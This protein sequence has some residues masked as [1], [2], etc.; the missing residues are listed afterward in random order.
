MRKLRTIIFDYNG[1]LT[2]KEA[3][4]WKPMLKA[5]KDDGYTICVASASTMPKK[6]WNEENELGEGDF[7][8]ILE[9]I[10]GKGRADVLVPFVQQAYQLVQENKKDM[11]LPVMVP[12]KENMLN[13]DDTKLNTLLLG[14]AGLGTVLYDKSM[15]PDDVHQQ[16][17]TYFDKFENK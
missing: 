15:S 12:E 17:K 9:D 13:V 3:S 4:E 6:R 11:G 8:F 5:L 16:I 7:D 2:E 1:T 10:E 14:K